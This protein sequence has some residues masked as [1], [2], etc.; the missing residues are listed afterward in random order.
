M[1]NAFAGKMICQAKHTLSADHSDLDNAS[2]LQSTALHCMLPLSSSLDE[3]GHLQLL[4]E[5]SNLDNE[6]LR[7]VLSQLAHWNLEELMGE[8]AFNIFSAKFLPIRKHRG[9]R[10]WD[11]NQLQSWLASLSFLHPMHGTVLQK[12]RDECIDGDTF[13]QLS[14]T[15][16]LG[17]LLGV[18]HVRCVVLQLILASWADVLSDYVLPALPLEQLGVLTGHVSDLSH[19]P[20]ELAKQMVDVNSACVRSGEGSVYGQLVVLGCTEYRMVEDRWC[21][22]G[23]ANMRYPLLRRKLPNGFRPADGTGAGPKARICFTSTT[24]HSPLHRTSTSHA[25]ASTPLPNSMGTVEY[26]QS[27]LW[28][29]FQLGRAAYS[30]NDFILP[31]ELHYGSDSLPSG[32]VSRRACRIDCERLPPYRCY[33]YAGGFSEQ[34]EISVRGVAFDQHQVDGFTTF[35]IKL[36]Q[37]EVGMWQEVSVTGRVYAPRVESFS[38]PTIRLQHP[39]QNQLTDGSLI[40]IGGIILQYQ[41]PIAMTKQAVDVQ[42]MLAAMNAL[43]PQCPVLFGDLTFTYSDSYSRAQTVTKSIRNQHNCS[44]YGPVHIPNAD[45]P[46]DEQVHVFPACGHVFGY[47]S[48]LEAGRVCPLCR[49]L[50]PFVALAFAFESSICTGLPSHVFNP[51]GHAASEPTVQ[52]WAGKQ[53]YNRHLPFTRLC[54][55]CPFCATELSASHPYSRLAVQT[56]GAMHWQDWVNSYQHAAGEAITVDGLDHL[57][58]TV[59][60]QKTLFKKRTDQTQSTEDTQ[61]D[62]YSGRFVHFPTYAPQIAK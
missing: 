41:H 49:Q 57:Q 1:I 61:K 55:I 32:P 62:G 34:Q 29:S 22:F 13:T 7:W 4:V 10:H 31:G 43:R 21:S 2:C 24:M 30:S 16:R 19:L 9:I 5:G 59:E 35:G 46:H 36:L 28:D 11:C 51:C 26:M 12:V 42:D 44:G 18:D 3:D 25:S 14:S 47:H 40:D 23:H 38:L 6:D 39:L 8:V 48:S 45:G 53:V 15:R 37:P 54:S 50:G 20:A 33:L 27:P 56:G 60:A 52:H 17:Y 58:L